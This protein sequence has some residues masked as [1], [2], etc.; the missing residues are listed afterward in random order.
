M[1]E[2]G[3]C[4]YADS[5]R[6]SDNETFSRYMQGGDNILTKWAHKVRERVRAQLEK[7]SVWKRGYKTGGAVEHTAYRHIGDRLWQI[8]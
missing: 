2:R 1:T 3:G 7:S 5:Y 8:N 6:V 4:V